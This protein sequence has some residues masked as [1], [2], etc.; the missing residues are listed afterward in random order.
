MMAKYLSWKNI[1]PWQLVL[2]DIFMFEQ[3]NRASQ[4]IVQQTSTTRFYRYVQILSQLY[5]TQH[6][7]SHS[8]VSLVTMP[9]ILIISENPIYI[10]IWSTFFLY[11]EISSHLGGAFCL[12]GTFEFESVAG[13]SGNR[14]SALFLQEFPLKLTNLSFLWA[15]F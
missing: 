10:Q 15:F 1:W 5:S 12:P 8:Y 9:S 13:C 4:F 7:H 6:T 14:H 2:F 11:S 3:S